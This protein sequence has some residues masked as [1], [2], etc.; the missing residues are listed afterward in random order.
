[1]ATQSAAPKTPRSAEATAGPSLRVWG[2]RVLVMFLLTSA[3]GGSLALESGYLPVTLAGH[4]GLA[5]VTLGVAGYAF[6]SVGRHYPPLPRASAGLAA[7]A[8]LGATIAGTAFLLDGSNSALYAM[9]GFA[10]VGILAAIVMMVV[11]GSSGRH[12]PGTLR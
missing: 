2:A 10:V 12:L 6:S 3:V 9:E 8:A 1:M 7:I 5:L 11:G 4:I